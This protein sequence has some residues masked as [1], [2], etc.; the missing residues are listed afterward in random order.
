MSTGAFVFLLLLLCA[1]H[2]VEART[3]SCSA[4]LPLQ[5][6]SDSVAMVVA[7]KVVP[8]VGI[9]PFVR[10]RHTSKCTAVF[11]AKPGM[12]EE[13]QRLEREAEIQ[14][15]ISKLKSQGKMKNK[16]GTAQSAEDAAM[17]EAEA[18]FSKPSPLRKFE[19]SM[20][21]RKQRELEA[22]AAE[23]EEE[24]KR[25]DDEQSESPDGVL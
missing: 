21:E 6:L 17:L 14:S 8:V 4:F 20:A 3:I 16:D 9:V 7:A 11:M 12:S 15:K 2:T 25:Q 24:K 23:A 1:R 5:P 18:F 13:R 19:R 22:A 10:T